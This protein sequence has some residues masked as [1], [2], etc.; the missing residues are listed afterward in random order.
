MI[1]RI[2]VDYLQPGMY[3][4]DLNRAW[5]P[6]NNIRNKGFLKNKNIIRSI[7][8]LGVANVYIDTDKGLDSQY[9]KPVADIDDAVDENM[10]QQ[11]SYAPIYKPQISIEAEYERADRIIEQAKKI[12]AHMLTDIALNCVPRVDDLDFLA[13]TMLDSLQRNQSA[14]I[15]LGRIRHKD[16]YLLE[17]SINLGII[18][19]IFGRYRNFSHQT[20]HNMMVGALLHD[21]GK[22]FIPDDVLKKTDKLSSNEE[23]LLQMHVVLGT[24]VLNKTPGISD[25]AIQIQSQ[26]HE[27]VDGTGYPEGKTGE[28]ISIFGKMAAI[29][30][31]FDA[32][33]ADRVYHQSISPYAAMRKLIDWSDTHLDRGLVS[34]FIHC[35]G[36]YPVGTLVEL[37]SK[38]L[39]VVIEVNEHLQELPKVRIIY[40]TIND[41]YLPRR[42][43]DLSKPLVQDRIIRAVDPLSYHLSVAEF[44]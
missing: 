8:N 15:C 12:V 34:D 10:Q 43:L 24:E 39:A 26:H 23:E 42:N 17:H 22:V 38:K 19:S 27:R 32:I 33:T 7:S 5:V 14:L 31:V 11:A 9:A 40:S 30:D 44:L 1:K 18:I 28:E 41:V 2:S 6:H 37:D 36:L 25:V 21:I 16:A 35:M 4:S 3:L 13:E 29:V 20:V